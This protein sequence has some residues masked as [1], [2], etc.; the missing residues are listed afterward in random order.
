MFNQDRKKISHYFNT[1]RL[2]LGPVRDLESGCINLVFH[3]QQLVILSRLA[4][5]D[6]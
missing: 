4:V 3:P 2:D 1:L 6:V 5:R